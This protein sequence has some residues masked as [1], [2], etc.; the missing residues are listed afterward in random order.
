MNQMATSNLASGNY[1]LTIE[2]FGPI[3]SADV[4][5]RPLTVFVGPSNTGKS[6][7]ATLVYALHKFFHMTTETARWP[8][9]RF[10]TGHIIFPALSQFKLNLR[11]SVQLES[12]LQDM[13]EGIFAEGVRASFPKE[14]VE[15]MKPIMIN[16][17]IGK[18][19]E[20][21]LN[22]CFGINIIGRLIGRNHTKSRVEVFIPENTYVKND[23]NY[24]VEIGRREIG[25]R[26]TFSAIDLDIDENEL[27]QYLQDRSLF[28]GEK[29]IRPFQFLLSNWLFS[30]L[31]RPLTAD[32]FYIPAARSDATYVLKVMM[33]SF[34]HRN[35]QSED[36]HPNR[37][38][39]L[40][41]TLGDFID[42]LLWLDDKLFLDS[43]LAKIADSIERHML[44]GKIKI[45][46]RSSNNLGI[47][48]RP[49]D[50]KTPLPIMRASSMVSQM[51]TIILHLRHLT[52]KGDVL[53]IEEPESNLHPAMQAAFARELVRLARD[54]IRVVL[55]THSDWFLEQL[56]NLV[57]LGMLNEAE[58]EKMGG[59]EYAIH[60]GEI[61][62]WLF[63]HNQNLKG[64]CVREISFDSE[65]GLYPT[66]F[67][68][69]RERLYNEGASIYN[70]NPELFGIS[71]EDADE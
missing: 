26:G 18:Q 32:A 42:N 4:E 9:N 41:G 34:L 36:I 22:H 60:S 24:I 57:R 21:E 56:G 50:W 66:D 31:L 59:S 27:F 39:G 54:G 69:V 44:K 6:Y 71:D 30:M 45:I 38:Q 48:Y 11:T 14:L 64:T 35:S 10:Q 43:S 33:S 8:R 47:T 61:G 58:Q 63:E 20:R 68:L 55:T 62:V 13:L 53:I 7:A 65:T 3:A 67:D 23:V 16:P 49:F 19:L 37:S 25:V 29:S 2:N 28:W 17:R 40:I 51:S 46:R 5:L 52:M 12:W 70:Q 1:R 15:E